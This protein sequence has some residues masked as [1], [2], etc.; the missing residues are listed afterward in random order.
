MLDFF[1]ESTRYQIMVTVQ[2]PEPIDGIIEMEVVGGGDQFGGRPRFFGGG[3]QAETQKFYYHF[4]GNQAKE[5]GLLLN[6]SPG[7]IRFNTYISQNLP[8]VITKQVPKPV[9]DDNAELFEGARIVDITSTD[10]TR[11]EIIVDNE[12]PGFKILSSAD[13]ATLVKWFN[14][15]RKQEEAYVGM[16]LWRPPTSWQAATQDDF[17]GKY[18]LSAHF[19]R[20]GSG[21]MRA[22]W[23]AEIE[24][25]GRYD[26]YF[27]TPDFNQM[28]IMGGRGRRDRGFAEQR[29]KVYHDDGVED[30]IIDISGNNEKWTYLGTYYLSEG[31]AKVELSDRTNGR[32][33]YADAVRWVQSR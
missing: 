1:T 14:K 31:P 11:K 10:S 26:V 3:D 27:Y 21:D 32:A 33:V 22:Q 6:E 19:K 29:F 9:V 24:E 20:A 5:I 7:M 17:Y 16:Q 25:S 15:T 28:R 18:K 8:S 2:N 12:D 13:E 30:I 4:E 23:T